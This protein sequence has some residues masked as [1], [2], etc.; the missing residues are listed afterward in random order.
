MNR[1]GIAVQRYLQRHIEAGLPECSFSA[2]RWQQVLVLPAY[3]EAPEL[4]DR[5]TALPEGDGRTLVILVLNRPDT[6]GDTLANAPL[7]AALAIRD[8]GRVSPTTAS[9][10]HLNGHSDLFL[11]DME[12]LFGATPAACGVGLARKAG[13][14]LALRW[15]YAGGIDGDWLCSTDADATL[16]SDYFAQLTS[17]PPGAAAVAFPFRHVA[18]DDATCNAATALYELRLH[19]YVLGLEYAASP[20]AFHTLGSSLAIRA[21]AYTQVRGFPK[22]A[23]GE[24][25][26]VLNKLAKVGAITRPAGQCIELQSRHSARTPFGTGPAVR[27]IAA[28]TQPDEAAVFYH[29]AC[30]TALRAVMDS[31][32]ELARVPERNLGRLLSERELEPHLARHACRA[33][34]A[35]GVADALQHCLQQG[36]SVAQ[37][38]R[39]FHQWFDGFRTL[40]FIH[41]LRDAGW[42]QQ[43]LSSLDAL[44]PRLWPADIPTRGG[45]EPSRAA[46]RQHWGWR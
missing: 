4:L 14:D 42:P 6:D 11:L 23:G 28:S 36:K 29:P 1:D 41:A 2:P 16:P 43:S 35:L 39:Q 27:A 10:I 33:L 40:K 5:L 46:I 26:Y 7:R 13:A 18:G 37:F 45:I 19:H 44:T 38:Q 20:Y 24:D 9:V 32:P 25:F 21:C 30:F 3:R 12:A 34:D 8:P 22:R 17:A 31:V 15:I